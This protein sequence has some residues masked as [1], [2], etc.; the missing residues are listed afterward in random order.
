MHCS[1]GG[2]TVVRM[3]VHCSKDGGSL[4]GIIMHKH[5][6]QINVRT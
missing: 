3:A 5:E 2:C 6:M 4:A 1:K